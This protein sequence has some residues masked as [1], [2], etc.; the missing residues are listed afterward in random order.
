MLSEIK[1]GARFKEYEDAFT[2]LTTAKLCHKIH[3]INQPEFPLSHFTNDGF[4]KL[5]LLDVGLIGALSNISPKIIL[6]EHDL[7]KT[8]KGAFTESFVGQ[9][10]TSY[11]VGKL[12]YW[13]SK[14]EAEVDY[15][16]ESENSIY[17]VE[18]KSGESGKLKSLNAYV[19]KYSPKFK[20]RISSKNFHTNGNFINLPLYG[21]GQLK[22]L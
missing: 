9:E 8:F 4:F 18:V 20:I 1:K 3:L 22:K 14:H 16:F 12:Y 10:L 6:Q 11:G 17:P 7:F 21:I 13:R 15:L 2:W 5:I 19:E